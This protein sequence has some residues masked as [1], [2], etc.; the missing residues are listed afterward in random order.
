MIDMV[1]YFQNPVL[2]Q[3]QAL[4]DDLFTDGTCDFGHYSIGGTL[5]WYVYLHVHATIQNGVAKQI[6]YIYIRMIG[7][8]VY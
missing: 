8:S 2:I 6:F 1:F 7:G 5:F 4:Y 3:R